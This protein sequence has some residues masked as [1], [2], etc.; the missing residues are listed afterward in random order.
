MYVIRLITIHYGW[1]QTPY[2]FVE[3]TCVTSLGIYKSNLQ[4]WWLLTFN[5]D[6]QTFQ[7]RSSNEIR[8]REKTLREIRPV[9]SFDIKGPGWTAIEKCYA[10][11]VGTKRIFF[12]DYLLVGW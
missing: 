10:F 12:V 11:V 9:F 3:K 4:L 5:S 1:R 2:D 8:R 6:I 7:M